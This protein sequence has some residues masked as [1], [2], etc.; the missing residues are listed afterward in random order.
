MD[1]DMAPLSVSYDDGI[2][3]VKWDGTVVCCTM[4]Q[5]MAAEAMADYGADAAWAKTYVDEISS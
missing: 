5:W 3:T 1:D 4:W 2:F